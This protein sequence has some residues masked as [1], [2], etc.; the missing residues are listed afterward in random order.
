MAKERRISPFNASRQKR[1]FT[2]R[3]PLPGQRMF[4]SSEGREKGTVAPRGRLHKVVHRARPRGML[5]A[6][7]SSWRRLTSARQ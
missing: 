6:L 5:F 3:F 2:F 4:P 1:Y 7:L